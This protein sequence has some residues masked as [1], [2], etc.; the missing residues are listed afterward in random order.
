MDSSVVLAFLISAPGITINYILFCK[1][2]LA[3]FNELLFDYV[4]NI[5]DLHFAFVEPLDVRYNTRYL[6]LAYSLRGLDFDIGFAYGF[7]NFASVVFDNPAVSFDNLHILKSPS[8]YLC[9]YYIYKL[10]NTKCCVKECLYTTTY[11]AGNVNG[12]QPNFFKNFFL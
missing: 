8:I 11:C 1:L 10:K 9:R 12:F 3:E 6:I 4:L 2:E 7:F 5:L